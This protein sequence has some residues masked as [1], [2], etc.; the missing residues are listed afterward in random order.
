MI[1]VLQVKP[2]FRIY[3]ENSTFEHILR[4][5]SNDRMNALPTTLHAL[6]LELSHS[7]DEYEVCIALG[8]LISEIRSDLS[9]EI[10]LRDS[11]L[12]MHSI[13]QK[14]DGSNEEYAIMFLQ[15]AGT[16]HGEVHYS[17]CI[18]S[19]QLQLLSLVC[20]IASMELSGIKQQFSA[21]LGER[22]IGRSSLLMHTITEMLSE[23]ILQSTPQG[24]ASVAGQF[25]MGQLMVSS[26]AIITPDQAGMKHILSSNGMTNDDLQPIL[27]TIDNHQEY[28]LI[29]GHACIGMMHGGT[30][31]GSII[32]GKRHSESCTEDDI[33]FISIMG[34]VIAVSLER[35][36][37][38]EEEQI[39]AILKKEMEIA[40]IVQ[41]NLLPTFPIHYPHCECSGIHIPSLEIGGDYMDIIPYSDGSLAVIMADVSGKGIG[42]AM[43]MSMVKS[44]CSL[45]VKQDKG[46]K[47]IVHELNDVLY[48]HTA[49]DIFVTCNIVKINSEKNTLISINAGHEAPLLRN[50]QGTIVQL[51]KG[52]MVLGVKSQLQE[53][54]CEELSI[55]QGDILCLYTDGV[56]DSSLEQKVILSTMLGTIDHNTSLSAVEF[57]DDILKQQAM[58]SAEYPVDDK[59]L[60]LLRFI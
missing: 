41:K 45:L 4:T 1:F 26:Y 5:V 12:G 48:N 34:M 43:I 10:F 9:F 53:I 14:G 55:A 36:R 30:S 25:L 42:S 21:S 56:Y 59:T 3:C 17:S 13:I 44:A 47:E 40:G 7:N 54:E 8:N 46:P 33:Y 16:M 52:C 28:Q 24:I 37:L 2:R 51:Q 19:E 22:K 18:E 32:L 39:L 29:Q 6:L 58:Q 60:L 23:I 50:V 38:Y 15:H 57:L 11:H 31:Y 35:A 20:T 27:S 49:P